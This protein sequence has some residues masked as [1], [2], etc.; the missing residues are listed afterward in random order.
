MI[1]RPTDMYNNLQGQQGPQEAIMQ[2]VSGRGARREAFHAKLSA[3]PEA[4]L[5]RNISAVT[6]TTDMPE[7][8]ISKFCLILGVRSQAAAQSSNG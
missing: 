2:F 4:S 1:P 6:T 3:T 5:P 8:K 7:G